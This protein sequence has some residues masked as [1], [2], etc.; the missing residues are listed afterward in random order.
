MTP[1]ETAWLARGDSEASCVLPDGSQ[2][3]TP[4][5]DWDTDFGRSLAAAFATSLGLQYTGNIARS[6]AFAWEHRLHPTFN[7]VQRMQVPETIGVMTDREFKE[8][9]EASSP[10]QR[11][12]AV[13]LLCGTC[14]DAEFAAR[15]ETLFSGSPTGF[16]VLVA[17]DGIRSKGALGL[18]D[19][20]HNVARVLWD[21]ADVSAEVI[22]SNTDSYFWHSF[23]ETGSIGRCRAVPWS[24]DWVSRLHAPE[25]R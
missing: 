7:H 25:R 13:S 12:R 18:D 9:A 22:L 8:L 1:D 21:P 4:V 19:A 15:A 5:F 24:S 10:S 23:G 20:I 11:A 14:D 6:D 2:F 3:S 17:S 16:K